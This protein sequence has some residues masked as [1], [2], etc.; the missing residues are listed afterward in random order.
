MDINEIADGRYDRVWKTALDA[1]AGFKLAGIRGLA[2]VDDIVYATTG[3]TVV[4]LR[5]V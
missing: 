5:S 3:D 2:L 1:Y 4:A